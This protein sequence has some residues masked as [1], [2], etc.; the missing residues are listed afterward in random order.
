V[1]LVAFGVGVE[2][3]GVRP[4]AGVVTLALGIRSTCPTSSCVGSVME[5]S[6]INSSTL[7]PSRSAI[8][9]GVSPDFTV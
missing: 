2:A 5:L 6:L 1:A 8:A 7:T 3:V 4:G 9:D